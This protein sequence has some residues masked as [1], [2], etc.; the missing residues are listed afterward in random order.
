[1]RQRYRSNFEGFSL[2]RALG[3]ALRS[4]FKLSEPLPERC[5]ELLAKLD[6]QEWIHARTALGDAVLAEP[7]PRRLQEL[8]P[9][10]DAR[11]DAPLTQL[12]QSE[13]GNGT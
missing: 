13:N 8:R 6:A 10:L 4:Q 3:D 2:V 1:M 12:Q 11:T 9:A 7:L 5:K